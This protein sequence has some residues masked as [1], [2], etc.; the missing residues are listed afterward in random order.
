[1]AFGAAGYEQ[2]SMNS[3]LFEE[4]LV[5]HRDCSHRHQSPKHVPPVVIHELQLE[6]LWTCS[7]RAYWKPTKDYH[8]PPADHDSEAPGLENH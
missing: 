5:I 4:A 8:R 3:G 7:N 6:R 2:T 1:M